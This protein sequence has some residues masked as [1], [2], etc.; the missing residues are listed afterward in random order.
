MAKQLAT[1]VIVRNYRNRQWYTLYKME[2][3]SAEL[4]VNKSLNSKS[5]KKGL[6]TL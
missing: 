5:T 4:N 3:I 6:F 1:E 2:R